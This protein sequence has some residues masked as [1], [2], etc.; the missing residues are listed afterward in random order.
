MGGL[1]DAFPEHWRAARAG[2]RLVPGVV[3]RTL[4]ADTKPPKIKRWVVVAVS[5]DALLL[6]L[7]YLN[8]EINPN[9][10]PAQDRHLH[11]RLTPD[12]RGLVDKG[13]Y[14]DCSTLHQM[15]LAKA[16]ALLTTD[17][18]CLLG[19]LTGAELGLFQQTIAGSRRLSRAEKQ[20]FGLV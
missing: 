14:A 13:C 9:I 7:V 6:G 2:Q 16:E 1:G 4:V 19:D 11:I 5:A 10:F 17:A 8:S 12:A 18:G 20:R 15:P 3:L